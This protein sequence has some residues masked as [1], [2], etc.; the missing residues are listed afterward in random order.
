MVFN[1]MSIV[2]ANGWCMDLLS[3]WRSDFSHFQELNLIV[4]RQTMYHLFCNLVSCPYAG[5][6]DCALVYCFDLDFMV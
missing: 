6:L 1:L 2:A 5:S 4:A 3:C